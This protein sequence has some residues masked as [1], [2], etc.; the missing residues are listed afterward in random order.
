LSKIEVQPERRNPQEKIVVETPFGF[1]QAARGE[2]GR[3]RPMTESLG[4]R[5]I[6]KEGGETKMRV[7]GW[8]HDGASF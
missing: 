5:R 8:A 2:K 6:G 4:R 7:G 1:V 3:R